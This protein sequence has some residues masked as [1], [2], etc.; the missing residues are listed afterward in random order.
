MKTATG[1]RTH[2]PGQLLASS[3]R[4]M[5]LRVSAGSSAR[6]A[7]QAGGAALRAAFGRGGA[8]RRLRV[9]SASRCQPKGRLRRPFDGGAIG[10]PM[11]FGSSVIEE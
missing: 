11:W 3:L 9:G 7:S 5:W 2:E 1:V 6:S 10:V 4:A 8:S